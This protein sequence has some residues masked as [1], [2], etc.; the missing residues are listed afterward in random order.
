MSFLPNVEIE[1]IENTEM[2]EYLDFVLD[3]DTMKFTSIGNQN[4]SIKSWVEWAI[5]N[6]RYKYA[7]FPYNYGNEIYDELIGSR[8]SEEEMKDLVE[9]CI[10]DALKVFQ[11]IDDVEVYDI[12]IEDS[13]ISCKVLVKTIYGEEIKDEYIL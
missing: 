9:Y 7:I 12:K 2:E 4:E 13:K 8:K 3:K 10:I 1:S 11:Y 6:E 5:K